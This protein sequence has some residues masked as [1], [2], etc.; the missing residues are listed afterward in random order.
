VPY[1]SSGG[2]RNNVQ[3]GVGQSIWAGTPPPAI[4]ERVLDGILGFITWSALLLCVIGAVAFPRT[5]LLVAV[6]VALYSA[7]RFMLTGI[8][9]VIG[10]GKIKRWQKIDW[11]DQYI[12]TAP[13]DALAW[14][15]VQHIVIIPNYKE[16]QPV[17]A[18]TLE[19]LANQYEAKQRIT[20]VL[21][22]EA[23]EEGCI[24][25]A[26]CLRKAFGGRFKH[27]YHTVHPRGLPSEMQ[28]KSANEAWAAR[29]IRRRLVDELGE[30]IDH[31]L[32]TTMDADTLWH[33]TMFYALTYLFAVNPDRHLRFWQGQIRYHSNVWEITP[34]MRLLN[35]Y[36]TALELGYL[37]GTWWTQMPMSSYSLSLRL[38]DTSGYWDADVIA[39]E[40]HM[41]IKAFF[42]R[43]G[44][45]KTERVYLPFLA[46]ATT[47]ATTMELIRNRY[48]QTLRHAWGSKEV[49]Y[50]IAKMLEHPEIDFGRSF[51][52][53]VREAHDII[54]AG[55]GWVIMTVGSQLPFLLH[56][57]LL[58][59]ITQ[60]G[61]PL[62]LLLQATFVVVVILGIFF[63]YLD[64]ITR[65]P[66]TRPATMKE[67]LLVLLSF[68]LLSILSVIFLAL[69]T[70]Q[71]Q[72]RLMLG[73]PLQF[74]VTK[75][76]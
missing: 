43:N 8:A 44:E 34:P 39:D 68:P 11:Y 9:A 23:S 45:V 14:D 61:N 10:L 63:W 48:S 73:A 50:T 52:L 30:D 71:A 57:Q 49:G 5:L 35:A 67:R 19:N 47:G 25:K 76:L 17:L 37:G 6:V 3:L 41:F 1:Q 54:Q 74:R 59:E 72:T 65:P 51:R 29:W 31:I 2:R 15:D 16:P 18:K 60:P 75:K 28:C 46:Q 53:L 36:S 12:K 56:P 66:R 27:F 7:F 42:A 32:V 4:P 20:I 58:G 55:A 69:P 26:E 33:P 70:I 24:E 38:L 62:W 40:W 13:P 21:A 22:M 64:V